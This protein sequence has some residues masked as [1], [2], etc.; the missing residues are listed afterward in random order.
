MWWEGHRIDPSINCYRWYRIW[1][2]PNLWNQ[3]CVWTAWG[4]LGT[5]HYRQ[6]WYPAPTYEAAVGQARSMIAR[7]VRRGYQPIEAVNE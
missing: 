7:K 2:Q 5:P 3:W 1:V 4:R 6:R